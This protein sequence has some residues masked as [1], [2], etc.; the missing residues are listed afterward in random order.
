M[1]GLLFSTDFLCEG[2]RKTPGWMQSETAFV[3]FRAEI[4]RIFSDLKDGASLNEAQTETARFGRDAIRVV[5]ATAF[6]ATKL[7][8]FADRG[9]GDVLGSH[10]LEDILNIIDGREEL[11]Q[12]LE[13]APKALREAA[14]AAFTGLLAR[15]DFA[16]ALPGLIADAG[17][18]DIVLQRMRG[19]AA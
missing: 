13:D 14:R 6:V 8:A 18:A 11:A 1:H 15:P 10:D 17:R 2:I 3:E 9:K 7:E 4:L 19:M 16:N 5:T 12:E